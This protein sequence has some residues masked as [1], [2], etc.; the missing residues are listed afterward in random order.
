[1][2]LLIG[3][4]SVVC[5]AGFV[6]PLM[7]DVIDAFD[8]PK[9]NPMLWKMKQVDSASYTIACCSVSSPL[10]PRSAKIAHRQAVGSGQ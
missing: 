3:L 7:A 1:M 9:L 5:L 8:T 6:N 2:F 10:L 4:L